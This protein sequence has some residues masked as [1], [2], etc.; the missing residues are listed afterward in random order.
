MTALEFAQPLGQ[1]PDLTVDTVAGRMML[2]RMV[3]GLSELRL[4]AETVQAKK[5]VEEIDRLARG[6]TSVLN[7]LGKGDTKAALAILRLQCSEA[8]ALLATESA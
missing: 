4:G 3:E 8:D 7:L 2:I 1:Q 5:A 6:L